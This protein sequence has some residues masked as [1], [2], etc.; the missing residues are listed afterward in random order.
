MRCVFTFLSFGLVLIVL[1][2]SCDRFRHNLA[3]VI[4]LQPFADF[5]QETTQ[6][7][8]SK[9]KMVNPNVVVNKSINFPDHAYHAPRNRYRADTLIR[10]LKGRIGEDT[11]IVGLTT[12]DIS[13]N[14]GKISDWGIMGFGY[15]PGRSCIVS[16]FR[17]KK[18]NSEQFYKVVIH[19]LGHTEGLQHC[20]VKSCFMR[21]AE[22]GNPLDKEKEFCAS[23]RTFLIDKGWKLN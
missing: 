9:M 20:K 16:S 5:P 14:K 2:S 10:F 21:D 17:L 8:C 7:I 22:G 11:V 19:E 3:K 12:K 4:V 23:C 18:N 1:L 15:R 13:V 6:K